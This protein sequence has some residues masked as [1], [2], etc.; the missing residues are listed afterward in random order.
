MIRRPSFLS[1]FVKSP[2]KRI[3][4]HMLV[5]CE[6]VDVFP[7]FFDA[8]QAEDWLEAEILAKKIRELETEADIQKRK[9][10]IKLHGDLFLPVPRSDI[11]ALLH[12]QDNIANLIE[13]LTGLMLGR[14]MVF[15]LPLQKELHKFICH[16]VVTCHKAKEVCS[17]LRGLF[18]AGFEGVVIKILKEAVSGLDALENEADEMQNHIRKTIFEIENAHSPIDVFFWYQFVHE[19]S[20]VIDWARRVGAQLLILSSR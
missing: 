8:I 13:D 6:C 4:Q 20:S 16:M 7:I 2:F 19:L 5:V 14:K 10:Q 1:I 18:E 3:E 15:P 11:L 17:E 12:V 9:I